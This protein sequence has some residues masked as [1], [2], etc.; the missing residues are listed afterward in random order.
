MI[1]VLLIVH[2]IVGA[3]LL[4]ALT[5]QSFA[6]AKRPTAPSRSFVGRFTGV[7][8]P[9]FNNVV[10]LLYAVSVLIG[11][12]LYQVTPTD[13]ATFGIVALVIAVISLTACY[14][15]ARRAT[16]VDAVVALRS[17]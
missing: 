9:T 14:F 15:P 2:V 6:V 1:Q 8:S 4:G 7:N 5:H 16:R 12:L 10:C 3:A 11:A 13:P 17:E